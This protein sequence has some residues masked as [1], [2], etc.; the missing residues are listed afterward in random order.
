MTNS[1]M[2]YVV[3]AEADK[4]KACKKC[5]LACIASHNNMTIKEAVKKRNLFQPRVHVIKTDSVKMP[6]QCRQCAD[7]PCARVCPTDAL[8]Q[9]DGVVV[10][11]QQYCAACQL[12]VMAC[13]YGA[14][15]LSFIGLP[16]EGAA[17]AAQ[18]VQPR[19]EV[20][21]RCDVCADWRARE[22][23]EQGACV[24]ACPVKALHMVTVDE[25]RAMQR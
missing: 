12:C 6:V 21:V 18:P 13:P 20:A 10:M 11:R 9:E 24:E 5:E 14:I 17:D 15:E 8:V 7:A 1:L 22:G 19:R 16:E 3:F 25:Y 23:K 2:R 4:C